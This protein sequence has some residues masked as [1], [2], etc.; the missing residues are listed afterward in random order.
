MKFN[1]FTYVRPDMAAFTRKF[2][3]LLKEFSDAASFQKQNCAL[4]KITALRRNFETMT[5]IVYIRH[6]VSTTDEFYEKE[7]DFFDENTPV[8]QGL[9]SE[10]YKAL[11]LSKFKDDLKEKW[12]EQIFNI[13]EL[14]MKIYNDDVLEDLKEEN[15]TS[16]LYTKLL[17]S[18]KIPFEGEERTLSQMVPF[19][20]SKDREIR[21]KANDAKYAFFEE[22]SQE[23][24]EIYDK[25]VKVRNRIAKKLHFNSF[26]EVAYARMLRSDYNKED[27]AVF[28]QGVLNSIVK[29]AEKLSERQRSRLQL[30]ELKYYD[31]NFYFKSGNPTPKGSHDFLV[32]NA[33][34][35]YNDI[36]KET[37]EFFKYMVD[38]DLLDLNS[39]KGKASG[40]YCT[41]IADYKS[42]FIFANFN[43]TSHD[44]N[45]L[46][47]EAGHAFQVYQ[48]RNY[49]M[50]EYN[51]PTYESCEIHS[52][53]MEFFAGPYMDKFFGDEA[54][55]FRFFHLSDALM[56]IPYG[57]AV[58]E[59]QHV[60]YENPDMT[61]KERK[62]TWRKIEKKYLPY[63]KYDG[64]NYL[65]NGG[66]WQQQRHIYESPFYYIDY[67]LAQ[68]CAFQFLLKSMDNK[69]AAWEDY[70]KLCKEGGTKSFL[71][72]LKV[73]KLESPFEKGCIEK[74]TSRIEE[75]L[76]KIDDTKF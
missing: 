17:A 64:S 32:S 55:K 25:L 60:I 14:F 7:Q 68:M 16:S 49:E 63:K 12:G 29:T 72:L 73:A 33:M 30:P 70:V 75:I 22:H 38:N 5:Q 40:G 21:K 51:F 9:V 42:P 8:Y 59:F 44:V 31:L 26:V 56:F 58:D 69:E 65:E 19:T 18:A 52:M 54:D 6:T 1:D 27:V 28:R 66:Y 39:K 34:D 13:A 15:K 50:P 57:V 48:S 62:Q 35:M 3:E 45:V 67:T 61:P 53:S 76:N 43:G 20:Q 2:K 74:I 41:F 4:E 23:F 36:S 11:T 37:G 71:K 10:F 24:D 47:H 46:T